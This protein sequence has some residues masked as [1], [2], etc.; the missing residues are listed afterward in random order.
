MAGT[1]KRVKH[2]HEPG[3]AHELTFSCYRRLSLLTNDTWRGYLGT[4]VEDAC[5]KHRFRLVAFVFMPEHVHLLVLPES[6][7]PNIGAFVAAVKRPT[8]VEVKR[9]LVTGQSRLIEKLTMQERPGKNVFRFWQ[10]GPGYDRNLQHEDSVL[11]SIDYIHN[12]PVQRGLCRSVPEWFWSSARF[13]A[14]EPPEQNARLPRVDG[15]PADFFER[16][17]SR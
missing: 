10:E 6:D 1:R 5:R 4:K 15:L 17:D 2:Y 8:S 7:D 14:T 3:D 9:D 11:G 16:A 12:N 13:Y